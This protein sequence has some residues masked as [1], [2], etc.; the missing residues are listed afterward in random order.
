MIFLLIKDFIKQMTLQISGSVVYDN[1]VLPIR[2]QVITPSGS[3][4]AHVD[5]V[6]PNTD[7][8]FT[9]MI[10][11]GDSQFVACLQFMLENNIIMV[12]SVSSSG[13]PSTEEIPDWVRNNAHWWSQDLISES[14]FI[15]S[16]EYLI[17]KGII[18]IS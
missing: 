14:D 12:S 15:N 5:S 3:G 10:N 1:P 18:R 7:G 16:L 13:N 2:I 17:K 9:K 11:A 6:V 4:M 8:S